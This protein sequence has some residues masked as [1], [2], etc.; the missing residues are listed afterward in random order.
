VRHSFILA[1]SKIRLKGF[2]YA[3]SREQNLR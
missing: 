2:L 1:L 3:E